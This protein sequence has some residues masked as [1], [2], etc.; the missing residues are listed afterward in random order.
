MTP[1][2]DIKSHYP[3]VIAGMGSEFNSH[4][5]ILRLAQEHQAAYIRVLYHYVESNHPFKQAH[6]A[7]AQ[8]LEQFD[9]LIEKIANKESNNIFGEKSLA[10]VW[11]KK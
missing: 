1:L 9:T 3:A 4:E 10:I 2:D 6:G 7:L 8:A 5:F 11:S